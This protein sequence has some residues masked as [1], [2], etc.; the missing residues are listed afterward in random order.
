[1]VVN[2]LFPIIIPPLLY[3]T[4]F[5][6]LNAFMITEI[7]K[8]IKDKKIKKDQ[9]NIHIYEHNPAISEVGSQD[10]LLEMYNQIENI[11]DNDYSKQYFEELKFIENIRSQI[12]ILEKNNE[13]VYNKLNEPNE[14]IKPKEPKEYSIKYINILYIFLI[15]LLNFTLIR[16]LSAFDLNKYKII[17]LYFKIF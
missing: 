4:T 15:L 7:I 8:N 3:Y 10:I 12:N 13:L 11:Q 2:I 5:I 6:S 16:I 9:I 17:K 14:P 1:M